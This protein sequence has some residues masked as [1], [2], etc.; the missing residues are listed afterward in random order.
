MQV[1]DLAKRVFLL[2][3]TGVNKLLHFEYFGGK[4][5]FARATRD[6]DVSKN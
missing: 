4:G 1:L 3:I 2:M 6:T 5:E